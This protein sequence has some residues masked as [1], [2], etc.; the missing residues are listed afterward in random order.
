MFIKR[1]DKSNNKTGRG[2]FTYRLCESYRIANKVRHRSILNVG[3]LEN[4]RKEDF[5][6]L[7]DRIRQKMKGANSLFLSVPENI[8]KESEFIY[9]RILH[10]KLLDCTF[11]TSAA[12]PDTVEEPENTENTGYMLFT[13]QSNEV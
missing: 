4:I 9:R 5:R 10:E 1:I 3:K 13:M 8:E 12:S 6:L 11:V 7:C 2:Y